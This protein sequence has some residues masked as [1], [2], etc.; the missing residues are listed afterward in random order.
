MIYKTIE[1][2]E[3]INREFE[4]MSRSERFDVV[5][6]LISRIAKRTRGKNRLAILKMIELKN[7]PL[8]EIHRVCRDNEGLPNRKFYHVIN[9]CYFSLR[10]VRG[11]E[12]IMAY[13]HNVYRFANHG[14]GDMVFEKFHG[15]Y[16]LFEV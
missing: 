7:A 12:N 5:V 13:I 4:K 6:A 11:E 8:L 10:M 14:W 2:I 9:D 3:K 15:S 1:T 16:G